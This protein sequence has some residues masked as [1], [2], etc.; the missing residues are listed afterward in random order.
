MSELLLK[1]SETVNKAVGT[2]Q[3]NANVQQQAPVSDKIEEFVD[4]SSRKGGKRVHNENT[5]KTSKIKLDKVIAR[6][7]KKF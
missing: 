2:P 4:K 7:S 1:H 5:I 6:L 3:L